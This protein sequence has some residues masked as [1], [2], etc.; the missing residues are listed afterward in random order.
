MQDIIQ[1]VERYLLGAVPTMLLFMV[2][3]AAYQLL[4]QGPLTATLKERRARTVGAVEDAQRAIARA[5]QRAAEYADKLRQARSEVYKARE[6]RV[7]QWMAERDASLDVARQNA[8]KKVAEARASLDADAGQARKGI[9]AAAGEL[10]GQVVR[11]VLPATAG[12]SR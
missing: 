2:L 7:K 5:E 6:Q 9:E 10:A 4:I 12:S 3:V 1:Q 8:E 11:A